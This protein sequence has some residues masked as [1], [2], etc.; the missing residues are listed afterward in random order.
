LDVNFYS[1]SSGSWV[2]YGTSFFNQVS[3][4]NV[5][6][7]FTNATSYNTRYWW[8][9]NV[10]DGTDWN[11]ETYHF[12]VREEYLVTSSGIFEYLNK[13]C[14]IYYNN[15]YNRTYIAF[16]DGRGY[17]KVKYYDHDNST[18]SQEFIVKDIV[19]AD[20]HGA[21]T[22]LIN[23]TGYIFVFYIWDGASDGHHGDVRLNINSNPED[24]SSWESVIIV[25][26][27]SD[28]YTHTYPTSFQNTSGGMHTL[29]R[30]YK[31]GDMAFWIASSNDDGQTWTNKSLIQWIDTDNWV[32]SANYQE[33]DDL[34][35]IHVV[36]TQRVTPE[37]NRNNFYYMYSDDGGETWKND[38]GTTITLPADESEMTV[39]WAETNF[40]RIH[41]IYVDSSHYPYIIGCQNIKND[42]TP[43][44]GYIYEDAGGW[45]NETTSIVLGEFYQTGGGSAYTTGACIDRD[46]P[47]IIYA[48]AH[49][50]SYSD[51][52]AW[53]RSSGGVW[54]LNDNLTV[55]DSDWKIRPMPVKNRSA[56]MGVVWA[57][58]T[59]T[60]YDNWACFIYYDVGITAEDW[61][62]ID[63]SINGTCYNVT[64]WQEISSDINGTAY[65]V[66]SWIMIDSS[67]NGSAYNI[68][69]WTMID[70]SINGTCWNDTET[71][72]LID[73]SINGTCYNETLVFI[74]ITDE[75]PTDGEGSA[76]LQ[77]TIYATINSST[78][79]TMNVS[80]YWGTSSG[81][82]N[83]LI[84]TDVNFTNSTQVEL[85][86]E[87]NTRV[88]DYYW[89]AC[90]NDGTNY[91]NETFSFTTEG[92]PVA[93]RPTNIGLIGLVVLFGGIGIIIFL[94]VSKKK[95]DRGKKMYEEENYYYY[96]DMEDY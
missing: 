52:E 11:N 3:G 76:P 81:A 4:T 60:A 38:A 84:G 8:S 41:D 14:A 65:N 77:P 30:S 17:I 19:D 22:I 56:S 42:T 83:T 50:S 72:N 95:N 53:V 73:Y 80:W 27:D 82:E 5:S 67:V 49:N 36:A 55:G 87:A 28:G 92:Y 15:T 40:L 86:F 29:Y 32:Y 48:S 12:N 93:P 63:F 10:T 94:M 68:T 59:Y 47:N 2:Q 7:E 88:T 26:S 16:T 34:D 58:G 1:N 20:D 44:L 24:I 96:E 74:T 25:D 33:D 90:A 54:T 6:Q 31:T 45:H 43:N 79:A 18:F 23:D 85:F 61:Q 57:N 51:M 66:T 91:Q 62:M 70:S 13:P 71:W 69:T 78:G 89:R 21:P 35:Y 64:S 9:C 39:V 46:N 37:L 75:Y